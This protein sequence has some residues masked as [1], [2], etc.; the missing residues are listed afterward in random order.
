MSRS[1]SLVERARQ[2]QRLLVS[3]GSQGVVRR[4]R[5][6][7]AGKLAPPGI[8]PL[9]VRTADFVRAAVVAADGWRHP[10]PL[11]LKKGEPMTVA[12]VCSSPGAGSGGHMTMF[13]MV[14]AL[15]DAGHTCV[16]YLVDRHG[17]EIGQ[18]E[19][20]VRRHW[21]NVSAPIRDFDRG[22]D[23]SHAV[24][25]TSWDTAYL[26]LGTKAMG[27]RLYFVQ[28]FEPLFYPAGSEALLA[29]ATYS[30]GFHGIT[31][32]AWLEEKLETEYDMDCEHFEFGCDL[33][34]YPIDESPD[35]IDRRRGVAYYCR[36][37]TPRRG[38]EL[39]VFALELFAKRHPE[40]PIH[41]YGS[42]VRDLPFQAHQHGLLT[43]RE[44]GQLYNQ[45]VA[46]LVISATNVSLVPWEM[47]SAG[48]TPVMNDA[49]HNRLVLHNDNVLYTRP[50][51]HDL[52]AAL[53]EL[54]SESTERRLIRALTVAASVTSSSWTEAGRTVEKAIREIVQNQQPS[55]NS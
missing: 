22:L 9:T 42:T 3:E 51:P 49:H 30:F 8:K 31:A 20:F 16:V 12:W 41:L 34:A 40:I 44:L 54:V 4:M 37:G 19:A 28:D 2:V 6:R 53:S 55:G 24:I 15:E 27:S 35:A 45:C 52:A 21:P 18:H 50:T 33:D 7:A 47:M 36:P 48:C 26:V 38:H 43:P 14:E 1:A 25:A 11:P 32:G 10:G 39:A 29:E 5:I 13:R 23:D 17:W 46:G